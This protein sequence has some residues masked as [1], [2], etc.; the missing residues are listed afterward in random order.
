V[1]GGAVRFDFG[2]AAALV[3]GAGRGLGFAVARTLHAAGAAVAL[4]D[5]TVDMVEGAIDRLGGGP[6]LVPAPADLG[7]AAGAASAVDQ[8]SAALGRLDALV[9]NAAVN[10]ERPVEATDDA[11]W[12]LHLAVILKAAF[13]TV[14]AA[15]PHL[16]ASRGVVVNVASELGLHA[17]PGNVAYV[18]AKHGLIAMTRATALELARD[19]VRVIAVCPGTLDTELMRECADASGD[20]DADYGAFRAYHPLGRL[21]SPEEVADL[22]LCLASSAASFMTGSAVAVDGGST[23]GRT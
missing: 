5:R 9:N 1:T 16:R 14:R 2:G 4:N 22:V 11:H 7:T 15:L 21:A 20:R 23:A 6:R 17:I 3:T 13:F 19:G 18:A 12:D 8:A 10:V